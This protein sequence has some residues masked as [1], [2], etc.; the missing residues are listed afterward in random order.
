VAYLA[1]AE[2]IRI[3]RDEEVQEKYD[4]EVYRK[5]IEWCSEAGVETVADFR[6]RIVEPPTYE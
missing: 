2:T 5:C 3:S 6:G 1:G 4:F